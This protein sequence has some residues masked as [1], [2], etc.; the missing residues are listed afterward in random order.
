MRILA[1]SLDRISRMLTVPFSVTVGPTR[2]TQ[3]F[4]TL[5]GA[6]PAERLLAV[7]ERRRR[8]AVLDL[9]SR[10]GRFARHE[11]L[12]EHGARHRVV[13]CTTVPVVLAAV[14]EARRRRKLV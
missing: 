4:A 1:E 11:L 13:S 14:R 9:L 7:R 12:H 8:D 6:Q 2:H 5:T 10:S 3:L